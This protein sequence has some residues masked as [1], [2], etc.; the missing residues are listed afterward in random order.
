[1]AYY[2]IHTQY[3]NKFFNESTCEFLFQY[4]QEHTDIQTPSQM[5][6]T[7]PVPHLYYSIVNGK[8]TIFFLSFFLSFFFFF[9]FFCLF[10]ATPLAY[11]DSHG[12]SWAGG[13]TGATA[14]GLRHSHSNTGSKP[15]L[16][17]T[18]QLT[19]MPDP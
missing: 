4:I 6:T 7:H 15:Y 16:R 9:F 18:P 13:R 10:R 1:M 3:M 5:C 12:D 14:V 11:G 2:I 8:K 19:A 17:R